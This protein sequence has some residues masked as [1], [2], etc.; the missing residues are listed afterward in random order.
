MKKML[1]I[2]V[3]VVSF[4]ACKKDDIKQ[5]YID[6]NINYHDPNLPINHLCNHKVKTWLINSDSTLTLLYDMNCNDSITI[7]GNDSMIVEVE[8]M[9]S[10]STVTW[11]AV[12]GYPTAIGVIMKSYFD[13]N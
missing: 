9:N 3:L 7:F 13:C 10:D 12:F 1:M 8:N 11:S 5:T 6:S 2:L 4:L